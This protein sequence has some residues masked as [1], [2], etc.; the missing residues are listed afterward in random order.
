MSEYMGTFSADPGLEEGPLAVIETIAKRMAHTCRQQPRENYYSSIQY[1]SAVMWEDWFI[2]DGM[3]AGNL[4][5]LDMFEL[6]TR[7]SRA[8]TNR[9]REHMMTDQCDD[10]DNYGY[11]YTGFRQYGPYPNTTT[12]DWCTMNWFERKM[13]AWKKNDVRDPKT[14]EIVDLPDYLKKIRSMGERCEA[15]TWDRAWGRALRKYKQSG[16]LPKDWD[17][18]NGDE[19]TKSKQIDEVDM[20]IDVET[21]GEVEE[22]YILPYTP[23]DGDLRK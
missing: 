11:S 9:Y 8:E 20:E 18:R 3:N 4:E 15:D 23:G 7:R 12:C 19:D 1:C 13:L 22:V 16:D 17:E 14:G 21:E 10:A 2:V 6:R 5:G